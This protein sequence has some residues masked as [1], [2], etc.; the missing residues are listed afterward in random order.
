MAPML[1]VALI[2]QLL[3]LLAIVARTTLNGEH[4]RHRVVIVYCIVLLVLFLSR[5]ARA[6]EKRAKG[7]RF[8]VREI[9]R[10]RQSFGC[11]HNLS[12]GAS[13]RR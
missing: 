6:R 9:F 11:Y 7:R 10:Q 8:W 3:A 13:N 1:N 2:L 4:L 5:R 12:S